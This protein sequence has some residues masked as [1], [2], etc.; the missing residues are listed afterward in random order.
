VVLNTTRNGVVL[1]LDS[2]YVWPACVTIRSLVRSWR[3]KR[4]IIV[5]CICDTSV[6]SDHLAA[7]EATAVSGSARLTVIQR[8]FT[9]PNM[10]IGYITPM[11]YARLIAPQLIDA[12]F[13]LYLDCDMLACA[14]VDTLFRP[15]AGSCPIAAARDPYIPELGTPHVEQSRFPLGDRN[16]LD[17]YFNSGLLLIDVARWRSERLSQ[18]AMELVNSLDWRP[19]F[20]D[21]DT[22]NFL[23]EGRFELLDPRWNVMP[24]SVIQ[25]TLDFT[26]YGERYTP[27]PY[28]RSLEQSPW[29]MHYATEVKPWT[30]SFADGPLRRRWE[31]VAAEAAEAVAGAG[32]AL[33]SVETE[34]R[35]AA[36]E[37]GLDDI[38]SDQ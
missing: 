21:Q 10:R 22:L 25:G 38:R 9:F 6:G 23:M 4:P 29:I 2:H 31:D 3:G 14:S 26:F 15:I 24:V 28:Q 11:G 33:P 32:V 36:T 7:L 17:P 12:E 16:S 13:L 27:M 19:L 35:P 30:T 8:P 1:C 34:V 37:T 5:Y 18:R 20:G